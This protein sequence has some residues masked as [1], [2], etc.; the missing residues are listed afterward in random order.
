MGHTPEAQTDGASKPVPI[1]RGRH[2]VAHSNPVPS[3]SG[4][5]ATECTNQVHGEPAEPTGSAFRQFPF[6]KQALG[7]GH[8]TRKPERAPDLSGQGRTP[9]QKTCMPVGRD[10]QK[11]NPS[12]KSGPKRSRLSLLIHTTF[13]T[14]DSNNVPNIANRRQ[15]I[16]ASAPSTFPNDNRE[17]PPLQEEGNTLGK[18]LWNP[19]KDD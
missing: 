5:E 17:H 9:G 16:H 10:S 18:N 2:S 19:E 3:L 1:A 15:T 12:K 14:I 6:G 8:S 11:S 13:I 7:K 4:Q